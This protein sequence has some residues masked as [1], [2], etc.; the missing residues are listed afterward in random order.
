M[1]SWMMV[2]LQLAGIADGSDLP[3]SGPVPNSCL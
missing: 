3:G 1:E 2:S